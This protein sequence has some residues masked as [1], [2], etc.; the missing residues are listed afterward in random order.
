MEKD[1]LWCFYNKKSKKIVTNADSVPYLYE[2]RKWARYFKQVFPNK[3][4]VIRK[5]KV[6]V[7]GERFQGRKLCSVQEK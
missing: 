1:Y 3:S 5:C 6:V 4:I 7:M 2:T